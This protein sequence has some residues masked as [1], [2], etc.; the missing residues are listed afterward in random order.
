MGTDGIM[1]FGDIVGIICIACIMGGSSLV[2]L[3]ALLVILA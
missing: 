3:V 2:A 1:G